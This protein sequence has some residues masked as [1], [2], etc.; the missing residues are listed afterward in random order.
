MY[1]T[2]KENGDASGITFYVKN[3]A[4]ADTLYTA[5]SSSHSYGLLIKN[6]NGTVYYDTLK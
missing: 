1:F 4:I 6:V 3:Q 5:L 2:N